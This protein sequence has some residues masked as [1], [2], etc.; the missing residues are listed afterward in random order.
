MREES[1][2][3]KIWNDSE[4]SPRKTG[5]YHWQC[6]GSFGGKVAYDVVKNYH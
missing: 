6:F 2:L 3:W 4:C 5:L 1:E